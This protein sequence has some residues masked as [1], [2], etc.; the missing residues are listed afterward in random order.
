MPHWELYISLRCCIET[1]E[2]HYRTALSGHNVTCF[3]LFLRLCS[4]CE[5]K[6]GSESFIWKASIWFRL[7]RR[8]DVLKSEGHAAVSRQTGTF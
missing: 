7:E 8:G 1:D 6:K 3:L 5:T 2:L 4:P